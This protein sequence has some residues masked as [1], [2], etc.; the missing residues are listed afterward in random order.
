MK[1]GG[2]FMPIA[3]NQYS[4]SPPGP[5]GGINFWGPS[6]DPKLHLF[7]S[8]T[9]NMFQPMRLIPLTIVALWP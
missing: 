5:A 7:I 6:Y 3:V 8:N 2:P 1:L 9:S 4:I